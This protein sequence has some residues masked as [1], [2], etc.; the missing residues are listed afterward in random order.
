VRKNLIFIGGVAV[1]KGATL[2]RLGHHFGDKITVIGTG[3]EVR[4]R[5]ARDP[6]FKAKVDEYVRKGRLVPDDVIMPIGIELIHKATTQTPAIIYGFDGFP[7]NILQLQQLLRE[8]HLSSGNTVAVN[9]IASRFTLWVRAEHRFVNKFSGERP[10]ETNIRLLEFKR[11]FE[12]RVKEHERDTPGLVQRLQS[13]QIK[14]HHIDAN[15]PIDEFSSDVL[16]IAKSFYPDPEVT[17]PSNAVVDSAI[18]GPSIRERI[19]RANRRPDFARA[20][21]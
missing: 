20:C 5:S 6:E 4:R 17:F 7:R 2:T 8:G 10:D 15:R 18:T 12:T 1:G 19:A 9:L 16:A 14:V 3:E 13:A 11:V 21:G